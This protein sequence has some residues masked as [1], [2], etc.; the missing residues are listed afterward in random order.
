MPRFSIAFETPA[1]PARPK[2]SSWYRMAIRKAKPEAVVMVG[3]Y[4]P[5]AEF[6]KL[7]RRLKLNPIFV[8]ISFVGAN[9]LAKEL[10]ED[11]KGVVV[12]QV[13]PFPGDMS[14]P[15]VARY[16]KALKAANPD[17]QIGFVSLEGYMVGRLVIEALG[18][19]KGPVTRAGLLSTIKE[20]GTFDLGGITLSYGPDNNQ[21]MD[22][23]F[24][25]VIQADGSFR[26]IDR[27]ER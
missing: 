17:A 22:Q 16:Q 10:G 26:P 14:I 4:Q 8:N 11:G 15:L 12:T 21:G 2:V 13:V 9:A 20:V 24:L 18:K 3:A 23:V 25:T 6:I 1:S 7:A 27:L 19:A 5:C